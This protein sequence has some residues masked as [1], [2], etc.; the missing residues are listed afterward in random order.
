MISVKVYNINNNNNNNNEKKRWN[1]ILVDWFGKHSLDLW[2][3]VPAC[4]TWIAW[5]EQNS[6]TFE[7]LERTLDQLKSLLIRTLFDWS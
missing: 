7:D 3:L 4:L 6:L 1:E 2:N 5:M